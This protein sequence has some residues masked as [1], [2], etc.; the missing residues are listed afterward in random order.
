MKGEKKFARRAFMGGGLIGLGGAFGWL[1]GKDRNGS[2]VTPHPDNKKLLNKSLK[3]DVSEFEKTDPKHLLYKEEASFPTGLDRPERLEM[4]PDG[5][6]LVSGDRSIKIFEGRVPVG[7]IE[8]DKPVHFMM[9][10]GEKLFVGLRDHFRTYDLKG[11]LLATSAKYGKKTYLT[12]MVRSGDALFLADAGN[13]EIIRTDLEGNNA[14]R[15]GKKDGTNPGFAVPSPYFDLAVAADGSLRIVNPARLRV[16][17]YTTDGRFVESWGE[18]GMKIDRFCGC[19]NPVFFT[20]TPDGDFITSEKGLTR[21]N[22]YGPKG[23]FK[24]A[25]AGPE[26]LVKDKALARK[27]MEDSN[28]GKGFDV[29]CDSNG[30]V[31][32]LDPYMKTV[33]QFTLLS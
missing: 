17:T 28:A 23:T 4:L 26:I 6:M 16:E 31:Y 10:D 25:V 8:P 15:F 22:V 27:A 3:Y 30:K 21:I 1:V 14:T 11:T 12:A 19:C 7:R 13:R 29:A 18:P 5:R 9:A 20:M 33:R 24:G 2:L 32:V